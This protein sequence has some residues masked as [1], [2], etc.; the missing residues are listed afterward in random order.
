MLR[1]RTFRRGLW[2][3]A[4]VACATHLQASESEGPGRAYLRAFRHHLD[5]AEQN[6]PH[7]A[8]LAD[9]VADR[10]IERG[11]LEVCPTQ[12]SFIYELIGRAS[13]PTSLQGWRRGRKGQDSGVVLMALGGAGVAEG[14]RAW[15]N[16][17][18]RRSAAQVVVF[19]S[20]PGLAAVTN[21]ATTSPF[22]PSD[23]YGFVDNNVAEDEFTFQVP[24]PEGNKT[25]RAQL[26]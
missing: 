4:L 8:E 24:G 19:A 20:R 1:A 9:G 13:G 15:L 5:L 7:I 26:S 3:L 21:E 6:V 25:R 23:F 17:G 10:F 14:H 11:N 22:D 12:E 16:R 18:V 2:F